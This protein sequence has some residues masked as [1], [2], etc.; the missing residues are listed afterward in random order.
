MASEEVEGFDLGR[1][2]RLCYEWQK[3]LVRSATLPMTQLLIARRGR[4]VYCKSTGTKDADNA[5]AVLTKKVDE[6][7]KRKRVVEVPKAVSKDPVQ[8]LPD[9]AIF[10][11][12]SMTKPITSIALMQLYEEGRFQLSDPAHFYLGPKW[13]KANL[14]VFVRERKD[15]TF[16][17]RP[18]KRT[19]TVKMLLTHTLESQEKGRE[20]S[21]G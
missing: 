2:N 9:D 21:S 14:S 12:Y 4:I 19:I 20:N 15:G 11:I 3:E 8:P 18:C 13:K 10:R 16:E 7:T 6:H 1:L 5:S 17:T